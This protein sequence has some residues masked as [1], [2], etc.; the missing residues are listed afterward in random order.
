MRRSGRRYLDGGLIDNIPIRA[1]PPEVRGPG[2]KI[3]C[4]VSHQVPIPKTPRIARA[5]WRS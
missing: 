3:L 4:L 1:L 2:N 5:S